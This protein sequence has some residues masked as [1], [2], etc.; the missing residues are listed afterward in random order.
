MATANSTVRT[1]AEELQ[2]RPYVIIWYLIKQHRIFVSMDTELDQ[3]QVRI[4]K[5]RF[6]S[7]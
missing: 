5:D 2:A 7:Q 6:S 3:E 4:I 1:L